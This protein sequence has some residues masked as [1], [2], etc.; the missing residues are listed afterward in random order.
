MPEI[1]HDLPA[2]DWGSIAIEEIGL[3]GANGEATADLTSRLRFLAPENVLVLRTQGEHDLA[4][5][6]LQECVTR[7]VAKSGEALEPPAVPPSAATRPRSVASE[8]F[9]RIES[10]ACPSSLSSNTTPPSPR[11]SVTVIDRGSA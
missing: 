11:R 8:R 2:G 10:L 9:W 7:E 5:R 4:G 6:D 3:A 1:V